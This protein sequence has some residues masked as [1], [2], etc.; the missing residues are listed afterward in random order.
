MQA[1]NEGETM[2][3]TGKVRVWK[4][5]IG[6]FVWDCQYES[7]HAPDDSFR[8]GAS[9]HWEIALIQAN[10]HYH[11][12]HRHRKHLSRDAD[13]PPGGSHFEWSDTGM[14]V[15]VIPSQRDAQS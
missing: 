1:S 10:T 5:P 4:H 13:T 12:W 2:T 7:C 15:R 14:H 9:V 11:E 3:R 6:L 8:S